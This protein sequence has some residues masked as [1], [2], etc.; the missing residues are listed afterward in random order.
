MVIA[1]PPAEARRVGAD[2][3]YLPSNVPLVKRVAAAAGDRVCAVG[4][5]V[6]V[7]GR[8]E[9]L[10]LARDPAGR[11]MPWWTGCEDL[12]AGDLFLLTPGTANA[13]DGRYF[14]ITRGHQIVGRARL[15][16]TR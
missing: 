6:S 10:R 12:A 3:H 16:W 8:L 1:W 5:A 15:L 7:N 9:T 14:G 11:P 2:R 4:E 13:F